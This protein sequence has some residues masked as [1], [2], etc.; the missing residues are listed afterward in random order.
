L[1]PF[2]DDLSDGFGCIRAGHPALEH[3]FAF[4]L[5]LRRAG[6][7]ETGFYQFHGK[8]N[9]IFAGV[10]ELAFE[11][12]NACRREGFDRR[13]SRFRLLTRERQPFLACFARAAIDA[14]DDLTAQIVAR[15]QEKR[16]LRRFDALELVGDR[17]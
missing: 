6:L 10:Q 11:R 15:D 2:T 16:L 1:L 9:E 8:R 13:P 17:D 4:A 5:R 12:H 3:R 14:R 7:R